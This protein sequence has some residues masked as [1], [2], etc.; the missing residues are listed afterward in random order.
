ML[1]NEVKESVKESALYKKRLKENA[2]VNAVVKEAYITASSKSQAVALTLEFESNTCYGRFSMWYK[3]GDG[4]PN[5]FAEKNLN[6][7]TFLMKVKHKDLKVETK[8]ISLNTGEEIERKHIPILE[9]KE[10]GMILEY[11]N[12][13][14]EIRDFFDIK[15]QKTADEISNNTE[16]TTV[17]FYRKKYETTQKEN[18]ENSASENNEDEFP[19]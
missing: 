15:S 14:L 3:K 5:T 18:K 2:V 4:T 7:M 1:W 6:R 16:S 9:G 17:E 10:I 12:D 11:R 19:F 13:N 8:K